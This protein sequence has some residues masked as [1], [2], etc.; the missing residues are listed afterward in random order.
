MLDGTVYPV[1]TTSCDRNGG[2]IE[3]TA[4]AS[5]GT[6]TLTVQVN[7]LTTIVFIEFGGERWIQDRGVTVEVDGDTLTSSAPIQLVDQFSRDPAAVVT[8]EV[9]CG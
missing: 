8:F 5:D 1:T 7:A 4:E 6:V 9:T 3:L 2:D